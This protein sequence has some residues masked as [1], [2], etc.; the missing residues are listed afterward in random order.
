[1]GIGSQHKRYQPL[2]TMGL[3][4]FSNKTLVYTPLPDGRVAITCVPREGWGAHAVAV[5]RERARD[6]YRSRR[7]HSLEQYLAG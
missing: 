7:G 6:H 3:L 5:T 2:Q 1:M 4:T